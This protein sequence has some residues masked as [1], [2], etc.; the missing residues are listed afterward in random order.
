MAK[1]QRTGERHEATATETE[2]DGEPDAAV[3]SGSHLADG[4]SHRDTVWSKEPVTSWSPTVLKDR[5][6]I[7][8]EWP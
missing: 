2:N 7:S 1:T 8:A 6:M 4:T 5:A 3:P